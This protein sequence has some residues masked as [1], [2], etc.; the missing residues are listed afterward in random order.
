M[1]VAAV[2]FFCA[3]YNNCPAEPVAK[4]KSLDTCYSVT[5]MLNLQLVI[6]GKPGVYLCDEV[7]DKK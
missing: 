3:S 6:A 4:F 2:M 5:A 1:L 7:K